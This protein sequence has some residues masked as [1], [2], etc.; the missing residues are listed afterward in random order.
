MSATLDNKYDGFSSKINSKHVNAIGH[1]VFHVDFD[2]LKSPFQVEKVFG[3]LVG[4]LVLKFKLFV[5]ET[6]QEKIKFK[7]LY[8]NEEPIVCKFECSYLELQ[9]ENHLSICDE[10]VGANV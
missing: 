7:L 5:K 10:L 2:H 6:D 1:I 9:E 4:N 8:V 3:L